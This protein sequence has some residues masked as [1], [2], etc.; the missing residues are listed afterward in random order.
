MAATTTERSAQ[1][2]MRRVG[3][4][5]VPDLG[6]GIGLRGPHIGDVLSRQPD[7]GWFEI[8]SENFL[9]N[10]GYLAWVL[11]QIA[12]RYP[13]V[14]H[15][16]SLSI[17]SADALDMEYLAALKSLA[18]RIGAPW[19]SDHVCWTGVGG[20]NSHDLLP[21]PYTEE[22][23]SWMASR[24]RVVQDVLERP[25]FLENP[26]SYVQFTNSSIPEWEFMRE[27]AERADCGLLIDVNN[28]YVSS[29]NHE[30]DPLTYLDAVPWERVAQF[31]VAGHTDRGS[32]LLDSHI[33]PVDEPVWQLLAEAWR[34]S[35]GRSVLLE[36]DAEIP[37]FDTVW[38][39]ARRAADYMRGPQLSGPDGPTTG[40]PAV[41]ASLTAAPPAIDAL[42]RWMNAVVID[43]SDAQ[44]DQVAQH[45]QPGSS[46]SA[47][48][49]VDIY[50][51]MVAIRFREVMGEDYPA[52][53]S[54]LG[55]DF[56]QAIAAYLADHP[57]RS[58]ALEHLGRHLPDWF[59]AGLMHQDVVGPPDWRSQGQ[60][61]PTFIAD[62]ARLE[63]A[64]VS[65]HLADRATPLPAAAIEAVLPADRPTVC[66]QFA[67]SMRLL[68]LR[69]PV[70]HWL[71][72]TPPP[73]DAE[74][75]EHVLVYRVGLQVSTRTL[76]FGEAVVLD[77]L[78]AGQNLQAAVF[79]AVVAGPKW[80]DRIFAELPA[81]TERWAAD[82]LLVGLD[83]QAT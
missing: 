68:R 35:G 19:L 80:Q 61:L 83:V 50:T 76:G 75:P 1:N 71:A 53:A 25:I 30:F 66:F 17:G 13:V 4:W 5:G 63:W 8:I 6:I 32:H 77:G 79:E 12:A 23:L 73:V 57:S 31:H 14:M 39:E 24:V 67:P 46:L 54:V 81:W 3:R 69:H 48:E 59:A 44:R 38:A 47:A 52:V 2:E 62:L 27:L 51:E 58:W 15:G 10:R 64:K 72:G 45:I 29:V 65:S 20:R 7:V 60:P 70:H 37:D 49:R 42:Q 26:S 40:P 82:G 21:V 41:V 78:A 36:W 56:G 43:A 74:T 28:I 22:M 18:D 9:V 11:D 55:D 33:G 34:R 16:V